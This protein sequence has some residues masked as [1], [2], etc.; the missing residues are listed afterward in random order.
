MTDIPTITP[1]KELSAAKQKKLTITVPV[2]DALHAAI[3]AAAVDEDRAI[4][5]TAMRA[6]REH[7]IK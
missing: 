1:G 2:D 5:V 3:S 4:P 7:F 6:L